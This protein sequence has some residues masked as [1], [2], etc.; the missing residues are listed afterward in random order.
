MSEKKEFKPL[1]VGATERVDWKV[2]QGLN[3]YVHFDGNGNAVIGKNL[4]IDG[5]TKLNGGLNYIHK[6]EFSDNTESIWILIDYGL[7]SKDN[8]SLIQLYDEGGN[9]NIIGI[10]FYT[11]LNQEIESIDI[12]GF[13]TYDGVYEEASYDGQEIIINT[14][15][16]E[17]QTQPKLFTH[18][19]TLTADKSYTLIYQSTNNL[20]VASIANLRT[21]M[22]VTANDNVILPVCATDL[23]GT[24]VLQVT[25]TLCKV[26][27][28]NVSAVSDKVTP[29]A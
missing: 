20:E 28:A 15:A 3:K 6:F 24:A 10:G 27:T 18:T 8:A 2:A 29:K 11:N 25:T 19:L 16:F 22:N 12:L 7:L 9:T 14:L 5:T 17:E 21:I 23:S 1:D 13:N 26:G 4:E